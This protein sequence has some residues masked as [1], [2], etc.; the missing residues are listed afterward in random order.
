MDKRLYPIDQKTFSDW[1]LPT[2]EKSYIWKGRPPTISHYKVFCAIL[3]ILRTGAPW[4]D[5]PK[6]YGN[7]HSIYMRFQRGNER[8]LW[9]KILFLLQSHRKL[10]MNVVIYDSSTFKYHR[11][12]GGQ[13]GGSN[14][15][16][17][18]YLD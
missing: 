7:W 6:F 9:W 2:I 4:R 17:E 14:Q 12:G 18:A 16:G 3:Y 11:H 1:S 5:L 13:K 8:H 10:S 15:R